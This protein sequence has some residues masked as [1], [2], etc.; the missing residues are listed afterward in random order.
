MQ[1]DGPSPVQRL[2]R[3]SSVDGLTL[4]SIASRY[5]ITQK[6]DPPTCNSDSFIDGSQHSGFGGGSHSRPGTP[7]DGNITTTSQE[8]SRL[9]ASS[10]LSFT[11]RV[12]LCYHQN[13]C[14]CFQSWL[15]ALGRVSM[16]PTI[17]AAA[18]A[19]FLGLIPPLK[20]LFVGPHDPST[21]GPPLGSVAQ[22]RRLTKR[23]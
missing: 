12:Q 17:R 23:L 8:S 22:V 20:A 2:A 1:D 3:R 10:P 18:L 19:F 6:V 14:P 15:T 21:F 5:A 13:C 4:E 7:A 9:L 16:N 11:E